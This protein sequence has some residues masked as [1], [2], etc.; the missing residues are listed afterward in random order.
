MM[1]PSASKAAD[2]I[3]TLRISERDWLS[4]ISSIETQKTQS[5][6]RTGGKRAAEKRSAKSPRY[7]SMGELV[8]RLRHPGGTDAAY[9]VRSRNISPEGIGFIH[10]GFVYPQSPVTAVLRSK[11][12]Q[13]M[14]VAGVIVRCSHIT[15]KFHEVGVKF[16]QPIF[17][18]DFIRESLRANPA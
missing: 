6:Q 2:P 13:Y 3:D 8:V 17:I 18:E 15:G 16:D 4:L 9:K 5:S 7:R 12:G 10:G 14:A 11:D 1:S